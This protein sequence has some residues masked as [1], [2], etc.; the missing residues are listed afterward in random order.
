MSYLNVWESIYRLNTVSD[1]EW[2]HVFWTNYAPSIE[3]N[4]TAC[5][6]KC[7]VRLAVD[8]NLPGIG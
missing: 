7:E 4:E 5:M 3:L 6:G 1:V 2:K 8:E